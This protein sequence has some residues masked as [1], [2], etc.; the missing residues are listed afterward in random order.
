MAP[1]AQSL[2]THTTAAAV[3]PPRIRAAIPEGVWP[4]DFIGGEEQWGWRIVRKHLLSAPA[5]GANAIARL[6]PDQFA[7]IAAY[8]WDAA[9]GARQQ[10]SVGE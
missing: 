9:P 5:G 1:I 6:R 10:H 4:D 2:T 3:Q 8:G 7:D